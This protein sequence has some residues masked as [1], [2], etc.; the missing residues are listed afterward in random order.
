[1]GTLAAQTARHRGSRI[2]K[3]YSPVIQGARFIANRD[4]S[5]ARVFATQYT[6]FLLYECMDSAR[7]FFLF[8]CLG[9]LKKYPG[10]NFL[11]AG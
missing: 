5:I 4:N 2:V 1:M 11:S 9:G 8:P 10:K 3:I 6:H 7:V